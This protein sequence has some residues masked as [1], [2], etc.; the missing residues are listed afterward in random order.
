M[1]GIKA[2][3]DATKISDAIVKA[4]LRRLY[5][6]GIDLPEGEETI[7]GGDVVFPIIQPAPAPRSHALPIILATLLAVLLLEIGTA[8]V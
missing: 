1:T 3:L 6:E 5:P 4:N 7:V 2:T 8:H